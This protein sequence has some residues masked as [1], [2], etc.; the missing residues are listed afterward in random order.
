M[1]RP[2]ALH[3]ASGTDRSFVDQVAELRNVDAGAPSAGRGKG[4][5]LAHRRRFPQLPISVSGYLEQNAGGSW[6][7][8]T[9]AGSN[10]GW[11]AQSRA[12]GGQRGAS[13]SRGWYV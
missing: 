2:D 5:A 10:V 4:E 11:N 12:F 1:A 13:S 3:E 8:L 9:G 6:H 7:I